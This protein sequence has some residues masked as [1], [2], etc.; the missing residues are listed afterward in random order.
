MGSKRKARR[1][2]VMSAGLA[3]IKTDCASDFLV[4]KTAMSGLIS[5]STTV[6]MMGGIQSPR[7]SSDLGFPAIPERQTEGLNQSQIAPPA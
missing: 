5:V 6:A 2:M 1:A 3:A 7:A 4:R